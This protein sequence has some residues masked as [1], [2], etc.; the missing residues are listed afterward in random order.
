[1]SKHWFVTSKFDYFSRSIDDNTR[2]AIFE[3]AEIVEV[4]YALEPYKI[5]EK[6]NVAVAD[7]DVINGPITWV[8]EHEITVESGKFEYIIPRS[9]IWFAKK[10]GKK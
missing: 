8:G 10:G 1:M 7:G 6:V 4:P 2:E 5:G 3:N 9:Q